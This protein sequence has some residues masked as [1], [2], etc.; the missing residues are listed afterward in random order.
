MRVSPAVAPVISSANRTKSAKA[1]PAPNPALFAKT[2]GA[3][4]G[5]GQHPL[6]LLPR[7]LQP[8]TQFAHPFI[9]QPLIPEPPAILHRVDQAARRTNRTHTVS[10]LPR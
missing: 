8:A 1:K 5:S 2:V 4:V 6:A 3:T 10:I 7:Q 9:A